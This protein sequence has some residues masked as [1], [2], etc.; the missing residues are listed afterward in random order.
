MWCP[1]SPALCSCHVCA[2]EKTK[3]ACTALLFSW[4]SSYCEPIKPLPSLQ[5]EGRENFP[6]QFSVIGRLWLGHALE[7]QNFVHKTLLL[8]L[9]DFSRRG[10]CVWEV[11]NPLIKKVTQRC[12]SVVQQQQAAHC[13]LPHGR[14]L[15]RLIDTF[16]SFALIQR[17]IH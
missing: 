2:E 1:C 16:I 7:R 12:L 6:P 4:P 15:P 17:H 8:C 5:K 13:R 14:R 9:P 10:V 3:L 11:D